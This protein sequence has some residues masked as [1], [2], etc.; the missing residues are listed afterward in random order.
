[1]KLLRYSVEAMCVLVHSH[2]CFSPLPWRAI[3]TLKLGLNVYLQC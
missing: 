1:M 3:L 2:V